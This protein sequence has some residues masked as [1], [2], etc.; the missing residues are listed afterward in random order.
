MMI[1]QRRL[2]MSD[3][4]QIGEI[5]ARGNYE[6]DST[7]GD[8]DPSLAM[9]QDVGGSDDATMGSPK[10]GGTTPQDTSG[11]GRYGGEVADDEPGPL[12]AD[13][14]HRR[15][16]DP[17]SGPGASGARDLGGQDAMT[18]HGGGSSMAGGEEIG[19]STSGGSRGEWADSQMRDRTQPWG[20][21]GSGEVH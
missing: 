12:M 1:T 5:G 21:G 18:T 10:G 8:Q 4:D 11:L 15:D 13:T 7:R 19:G 6:S 17:L 14:P 2:G 20:S 9:G 3:Q 16:H